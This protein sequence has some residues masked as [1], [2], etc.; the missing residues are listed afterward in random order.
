MTVRSPFDCSPVTRMERMLPPPMSRSSS[1]SPGLRAYP[2]PCRV[3]VGSYGDPTT[4]GGNTEASDRSQPGSQTPRTSP[5][6]VV[7]RDSA[8]GAGPLRRFVEGR[9]RTD[10]RNLRIRWSTPLT[11]GAQVPGQVDESKGRCRDGAGPPVPA[12]VRHGGH[13]QAGGQHEFHTG[14]PQSP[15]PG[16]H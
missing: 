6:M 16:E 3:M 13:D 9:P 5:H 4:R 2:R 14:E 1:D 15:P 11:L 7:H 8:Q 12:A 10:G